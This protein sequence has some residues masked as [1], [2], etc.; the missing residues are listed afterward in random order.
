MKTFLTLTLLLIAGSAFAQVKSLGNNLYFSEE[1]NLQSCTADEIKF[2]PSIH[3]NSP[4]S[5]IEV[6]PSFI[7]PIGTPLDQGTVLVNYVDDYSLSGIIDYMGEEWSYDGHN[8]TDLTLH[9]FREMDRFVPVYAAA[10]GTVEQIRFNQFD[11]N[12]SCTG[13][14]NYILIR[15]DDGS[16]AYYYHLMKNSVTVKLG[17]YVQQG[18]LIGWVGS[19]GCSTDAHLHFECGRFVNGDWV[20]RDPWSGTYNNLPSLWQSQAGYMG[21]RDF[22]AHDMGAFVGASVP[23]GINDITTEILKERIIDPVTVS[24]YEPEVG[25]WVLAQGLQGESF[26][27]EVRRPNGTLFN[28]VNVNLYANAQYGRWWWTPN[29]NQGLDYTG[30]WYFRIMNDGVE[31]MRVNFNVQLLTSIRPRLYPAAAKCFRK[32]LFLQRDTLRVRPVRSNME[33]ELL[34]APPGVTL[35]ND[36][37]IR[38]SATSQIFRVHEFKVIASMG[39][40]STL[41]DT[42]IYK[43]IDTTKNHPSSNGIVSLELE[44]L[45]EGL[46]NG[47]DMV[48]DTVNVILRG[49]LSPYGIIDSDKIKLNDNGFGIA[50]FPDAN[51]GIYYYLVVKHRNSIETWSNN[52]MTFTMGFPEEYDFTTS[53][54]QAYGNNLK[55]KSFRYCIYSGDVNQDGTI[56]ISDLIRVYNETNIFPSGYLAEDVDGDGYVDLSDLTIVYNNSRNFISIIRP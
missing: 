13:S 51:S 18:K 7:W 46:Y 54:S 11:R 23:G 27:I 15:H 26:T 41:R 29:F 52:A 6:Y 24:G 2:D 20:K 49:A 9:S 37:I 31:Q 30:N 22:K 50:N 25:M 38:I 43:L 47:T 5:M 32:S 19:S 36:S 33:Y 40:S 35:T 45:I 39:G 55:Y 8:G 44:T 42:M 1:K 12:M 10:A 53:S 3:R 48:E 17:E 28:S 56:D 21:D 16:Y 14:S 34:N 4:E